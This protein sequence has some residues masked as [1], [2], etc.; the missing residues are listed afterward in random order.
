M[1]KLIREMRKLKVTRWKDLTTAERI[2]KVVLSLI[3]YA[4][5]IALI[6]TVA[7]VVLAIAAGVFVAFAVAGA[8]S[9][10]FTEASHAHR[11]GDRYVRFR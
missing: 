3:K 1:K 2:A 11:A 9:G 8:I 5:I 6:V 4:V 7:G 10:G